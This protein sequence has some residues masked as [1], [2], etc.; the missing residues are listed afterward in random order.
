MGGDGR[1]ARLKRARERAGAVSPATAGDRQPLVP[2]FLWL[3]VALVAVYS[4]GALTAPVQQGLNWVSRACLV[5]AVAALGMKTSLKYLAEAGWRPILLTLVE[6][7]RMDG[8]SV[9]ST[10]SG[11]ACLRAARLRAPST[12]A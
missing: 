6:T 1:V 7:L 8:G 9:P 11:V 4:A 10:D 5:V 12:T 2:R 3:F